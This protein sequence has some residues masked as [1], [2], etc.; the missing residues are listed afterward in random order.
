MDT[1]ML[2]SGAFAKLCGTQ[3]G[4][5]LFYD[6][7]GLLKPKH[8]SE[9]GYRRYGIEQFFEFDLLS[10][11]RNTGSSLKEIK[12]YLHHMDGE[13]FLNFL[14]ERQDFVTKELHTLKQ[15]NLMLQDMISCLRESIQFQYDILMIQHHDEELF[16]IMPTGSKPFESQEESVQR[17]I[18]YNNYIINQEEMPR[19]PFGVILDLEDVK[20]DNHVDNYYFFKKRKC[21]PC[22]SLHI[23]R[24]GMYAV[25]G[26]K[27]TDA[28]HRKSLRD[29]I[30]QI[31]S[32]GM[33]IK[34]D[35]YVY[36]MMSYIIR[37]D[38]DIYAQKYCIGV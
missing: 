17:L 36:D 15:R 10:V 5:L 27:G 19:Y 33:T 6:K 22:S 24:E 7:E 31:E 29:M 14:E 32:S 12:K 1:K 4:T 8:I 16:E 18:N 37:K 3:K 38:G 30:G 21:T 20:Q 34:S 2:T 25:M 11:L 28:T 13:E 26:H 23:K 35:I 9:N